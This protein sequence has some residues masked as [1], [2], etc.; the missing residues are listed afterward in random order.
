MHP[1]ATRKWYDLPFAISLPS[2][3][4]VIRSFAFY[5][6][7]SDIF[8]GFLESFGQNDPCAI[9]RLCIAFLKAKDR[10]VVQCLDR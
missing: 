2:V 3:K 1:A 6:R 8:P 4:V 7:F 9:D 5:D 10:K